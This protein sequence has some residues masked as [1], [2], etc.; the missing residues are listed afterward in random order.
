MELKILPVG[1]FAVN[2]ALVFVP[3][4][5]ELF[6]VDPGAEAETILAAA[7]KFPFTAARILLTHAHA[8]HISGVGAVAR[9]LGV[10]QA[11]L[12]PGDFAIY[13]S[14][15]NA[16]EPYYAAPTDLPPAAPISPVS[17]CTVLELPGH[18][19]GGSGFLFDDGREKFLLAGD[20]IFCGS[21]GRTDLPGGDYPTLMKSITEKILTL[22]PDLTVY[23]G[24]GGE[25]TVA[26]ERKHNP[27]LAE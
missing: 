9:A 11:E 13:R 22:P 5:A 19:P 24:H 17:H 3:E 14:P 6:I 8:D 7:R 27:Y 16:I 23:P 21:I 18:S 12:N 25:T 26:F 4:T 20:T 2:C 1:P 15:D 10:K